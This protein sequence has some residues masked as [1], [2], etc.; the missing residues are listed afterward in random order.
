MAKAKLLRKLLPDILACQVCRLKR[1]GR[2]T[3]RSGPGGLAWRSPPW[4]RSP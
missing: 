1:P 2:H 4:R 3:T